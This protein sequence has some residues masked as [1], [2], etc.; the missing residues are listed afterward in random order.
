MSEWIEFDPVDRI[1]V[2]AVGPLGRR[3]FLIQAGRADTTL[4]VLVEKEQVALLAVRLLQLLDELDQQFPEPD[5]AAAEV[6]PLQEEAAE[7]LFR[8][9]LLR[10]GFDLNRH[11]MVLELFEEAPD[12]V[13]ALEHLGLESGELGP[14]S[15][16]LQEVGNVARLF[17]TRAQMRGLAIS[18]AEAVASGRPLCRLCL[19]PVDP[20]GHDCPSRN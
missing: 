20:E 17:A 16:L 7:P 19:L 10:V 15:P 5:D 2:G 13:E 14:G 4:T 6:V 1:T 12:E 18:G 3:R 8:A 9:R 11:L